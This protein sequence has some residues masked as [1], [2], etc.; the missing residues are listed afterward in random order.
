MF[1][2]GTH[3]KENLEN[4]C[5]QVFAHTAP[6]YMQTPK[7]FQYVSPPTVVHVATTLLEPVFHMT[8]ISN[9]PCRASLKVWTALPIP[10]LLGS[11]LESS[12]M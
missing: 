6:I 12:A 9:F 2:I 10:S 1:C 7:I 3:F 4:R 11:C 5:F 8:D